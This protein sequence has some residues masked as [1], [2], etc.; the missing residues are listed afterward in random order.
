MPYHFE[1]LPVHPPPEPLESLTGYLIRL[2]QSNDILS[3]DGMS[4]LCFPQQD[5]RIPR[6]LADYPPLSFSMLQAS[7]MCP[8]ARLRNT[9][10][11]HLVIKF[12]RSPHPQ[13]VSRFLSGS[14]ATTLRYCPACLSE[15]LYYRLTWRF[16]AVEGCPTHSCR[17]LE[18]C[19]YC[20]HPIP[21]FAAPLKIGVC[22]S[23]H[24]ELP[25]STFKDLTQD[26][27]KQVNA[28]TS[29]LQFLLAPQPWEKSNAQ[30][31]K[32][33]GRL[34]AIRRRESH[35]TA[36]EVATRLGITL[37]RVEG[38]ERGNTLGRGATLSNYL[39]YADFL[40]MSLQEAFLHVLPQS[41]VAPEEV[42]AR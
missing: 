19:G 23:C 32:A 22:P 15:R 8:E 37:S 20:H 40:H 35:M 24:H 42:L 25:T 36:P 31:V 18:N 9:T 6:G 12:G 33:L 13:P 4:A 10:F 39:S 17:L 30:L 16:L 2:A 21:L 28:R 5:R 29:D 38:M 27:W 11:L 41:E 26:L 3:V 1:C 7:T 14:L 34:L